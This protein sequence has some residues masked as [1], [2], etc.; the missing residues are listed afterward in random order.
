MMLVVLI[1]TSYWQKCPYD[2]ADTKANCCG[3]P[4]N[5]ARACVV[6][7]DLFHCSY[8]GRVNN[9]R[10]LPDVSEV[11]NTFRLTYTNFPSQC[12]VHIPLLICLDV[13]VSKSIETIVNPVHKTIK[14]R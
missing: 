7:V 4:G 11:I 12:G 9:T 3:L 13:H 8:R 10:V 2:L 6:T 5:L 1:I 14:K